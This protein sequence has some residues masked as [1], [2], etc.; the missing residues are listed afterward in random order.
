MSN[1]DGKTK[2]FFDRMLRLE[3]EK[4]EIAESMRDL[5]KEMKGVGFNKE[6][7]AG[8][9]LA[10]KRHFETDEKRVSRETAESIAEALGDFKDTS[11]GAA[12]VDRAQPK[13]ARSVRAGADQAVRR[14]AQK[15]VDGIKAG[16]HDVTIQMSGHEPI[17]IKAG[18]GVV[19]TGT[20]DS[21]GAV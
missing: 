19:P 13:P 14:A 17:H 8:I 11:I 1:V 16:D 18:V 4:R 2:S 12:A 9:K 21:D 5:A 3:T 15:F 7:I 20:A 10:V 6:D